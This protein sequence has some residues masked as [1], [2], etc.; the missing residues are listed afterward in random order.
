M[1]RSI[2]G[3]QAPLG[4]HQ[5]DGGAHLRNE[6]STRSIGT[7]QQCQRSFGN[8][9]HVH[10]MNEGEM[11]NYLAEGADD[12]SYPRPAQR[13]CTAPRDG[14][15]RRIVD[16]LRIGMTLFHDLLT[17]N[18]AFSLRVCYRMPYGRI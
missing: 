10:R 8:V 9:E 7:A 5:G 1:V 11:N 6:T 14:R 16:F 15:T 2:V 18:M 13:Q 12:E 4:Q 3:A 17:S